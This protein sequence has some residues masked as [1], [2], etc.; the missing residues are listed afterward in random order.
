LPDINVS[1]SHEYARALSQLTGDDFQA[2]VCVR[3]GNAI[4]SFQD[5][6]RKPYG[7]GGLDGLSH[8]AEHA[9]CCYGPEYDKFKVAKDLAA[10]IVDKFRSDLRKLFELEMDDGKIVQIENK[11]IAKIL[12]DGTTLK[13]IR[14]IVNWFESHRIIG[15]IG[16]AV[17]KYRKASMCRYVDEGASVVVWGPKQLATLYPVDESTILRSRHAKFLREV[18]S[19]AELVA[20]EN[21]SDFDTKMNS[22]SKICPAHQ[23]PAIASLKES[24]LSD[25]RM[26]LAFEQKL[27]GTLPTLHKALEDH[28]RRILQ[29][30]AQLMIASDKPW[31]ELGRAAEIATGVLAP[32][33]EAAFGTTLL[34]AISSGEV[35]RLIGEC[36]ISWEEPAHA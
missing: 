32:D 34:S 11:E 16:T 30:V 12:P 31:A 18:L 15:P 22:L 20:I 21:P 28:R 29:K 8:D 23:A 14:L 33:F 7:D 3:L 9:Y 26:A 27:D 2:E 13:H 25:W 1:L 6:P 35:A 24:L 10:D 5:V 36:P 4:F 19:A 17:K